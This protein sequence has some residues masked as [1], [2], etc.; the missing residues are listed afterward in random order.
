MEFDS[1][2]N[3]KNNY[4]I[5][6]F[7]KDAKLSIL[8]KYNF[9]NLDLIFKFQKN[10][11]ILSDINFIL[12]NLN[13][14]SKEISKSKNKKDY[15]VKGNLNHKELQINDIN[16]DLF[17]KRFLPKIDVKKLRLSSNNDFAF[18]IDNKFSFN[19]FELN[20]K[21]LVN[22]FSI[23]NDF[24]LKNYFSNIKDNFVFSDHEISIKFLQDDLFIDGK[25]KI[26]TQ[27]N[28][29][30]ISYNI[31]KSK[32]VLNFKTTYKIND[33]P[34]KIDFLNYKKNIKNE[35]N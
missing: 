8:K 30:I 29:D 31:N 27:E 12:N 25:G 1:E 11:L 28:N 26:L 33:N 14:S 22:E 13:L 35:Y 6:G 3:I 32:K 20:S 7:I 18:K 21:I 34:L 5:N 4:T 19:N 24:N 2:G 23:N 9:K 10:D 17:I 16:I 15:F